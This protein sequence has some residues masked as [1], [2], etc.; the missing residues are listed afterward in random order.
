MSTLLHALLEILA[1]IFL[2]HWFRHEKP[3]SRVGESQLDR[4]ALRW[5]WYFGLG[6]MFMLLGGWAVY[7]FFL[8]P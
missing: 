1:D 3:P 4:D 5:A 2:G 6:L 7:H 8:N